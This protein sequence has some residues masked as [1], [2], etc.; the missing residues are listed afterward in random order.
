MRVF[1]LAL[2][3][4]VLQAQPTTQ[5]FRDPPKEFRPWV[6]W[7]WFGNQSQPT[8][9]RYELQQMDEAGIGGAQIFPVYPLG[10]KLPGAAIYSP[11]FAQRLESA[12]DE[13]QKRG[14]KLALHGGAGW[15]F[16][17][18]WIPRERSSRTLARGVL[19][20]RGPAS[21]DLPLPT[22]D[23]D[24]IWSIDAVEAAVAVSNA[25]RIVIPIAADAKRL[26]W[27]A[28]PGEW[29]V[30][31]VYRMF[32]N[33][34]NERGSKSDTG[35]VLDH[36]NRD[37]F[38]L[39]W[40]E[41][42]KMLPSLQGPRKQAFAAFSADSLELEDANWTP[43]FFDEFAKRRSYDLRPYLP[44]LWELRETFSP[45][46]RQDFLETVSDLM[47]ENYFA[48]FTQRA[49]E[50]GAQTLVQAHGA[51]ADVIR[52]YG[53]V[54]LPD[55][56]TMWPGSWR[57]EVNLRSRRIGVSAAHLYGKPIVTAESYTWLN[58]PRFTV[59]LAQMKAA[60]DALFLDGVNRIK[61]HG[62]SSSPVE[63]GKPGWVFYASTLINHNQT[64]WPHFPALAKYIAR[65]QS[66]LQPSTYVADLAVYHNLHDARAHYNRPRPEWQLDY[67]WRH[68]ERD[69]GVDSAAMIAESLRFT[70]QRLQDAGFGFDIVND[71][72]WQAIPNLPHRVLLFADTDSVPV[73]TLRRALAF[74]RGGG[75]VIAS[76]RV[77]RFG[78]GLPAYRAEHK[79]E[80]QIIHELWGPN[81]IG[82]FTKDLD[83]L[84]AFLH[85]RL[86]ADFTAR[87]SDGARARDIGFIHRK[88]GADDI[89]FVASA[90]ATP[91][92]ATLSLRVPKRK[93]PKRK[94]TIYNAMDG[95]IHKTTNVRTAN[96]RLE[97]DLSFEAWQSHIVRISATAPA[98]A[99]SPPAPPDYSRE[100]SLDGPWTIRFPTTHTREPLHDWSTRP[101]TKSFS[102][103]VSYEKE[104]EVPASA[105]RGQFRL[106]LGRVHESAQVFLNGAL[107]GTLIREPFRLSGTGLRPGRNKLEIR[108]A[109]LW[110]NAVMDMP[111]PSGPRVSPGYGIAEVLYGPKERQRLPS[112]LLGPVKLS[113]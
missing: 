1:A 49:K 101:E 36:F 89:Y 53:L 93:V 5:E 88:L 70:A 86:G 58:A 57:Q 94:V 84:E 51:N 112:G 37:A 83:A 8:D 11:G 43:A 99:T 73:A 72:A 27:Q 80:L 15:P 22:P 95:A 42:A 55:V 69:P 4:L 62:Y 110:N 34:E 111:K 38:D 61:A 12:L 75:L 33:Q 63:V 78:V 85:S 46:V 113:Y 81:G 71:H 65:V 100:L 18:P 108:V 20:V 41:V 31:I 104:F 24:T 105:S 77:P 54:D 13:A 90:S 47:L 102:G 25:R 109:N 44:D 67:V 7:W 30:F 106:D 56:E 60:T 26:S 68:R 9:L 87:A 2:F 14:L 16:G 21:I 6:L 97:F 48:H 107:V 10:D 23:A 28:P 82:H 50:A 76:G 96:G 45:G 3:A 64:W 98:E 17:G 59:T 19:N 74:A 39:Q 35:L 92:R 103:L 66:W 91:Q 79:E 29:R 52:A 40:R 32:T